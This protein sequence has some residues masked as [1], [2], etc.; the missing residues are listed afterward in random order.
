MGSRKACPR[1]VNPSK[2]SD[3]EVEC[4][5]HGLCKDGACMCEVNYHVEPSTGT[6]VA[7][8]AGQAAICGKSCTKQCLQQCPQDQEIAVYN[9]CITS[10]HLRQELHKAVPATVPSGP[11]NRCVQCMHYLLP[12]NVQ[13]RLYD[14]PDSE[15]EQLYDFTDSS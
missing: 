15:R 5:G 1:S 8:V 2:S 4:A 3:G 6:C 9:A 13:E 7:S 10:C 11:G 12:A 14:V